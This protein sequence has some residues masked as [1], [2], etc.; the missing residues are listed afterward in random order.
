MIPAPRKA[1]ADLICDPHILVL[2][3]REAIRSRSPHT[4]LTV[5]RAIRD[6]AAILPRATTAALERDITTWLRGHGPTTAPDDD[7]PWQV[8]LAALGARPVNRTG[9][10]LG[11]IA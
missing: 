10:R 3:T 1:P 11:A 4:A 9:S 6:N 8:A 7:R 5:V 2:A